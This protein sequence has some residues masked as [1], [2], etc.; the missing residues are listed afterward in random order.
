M[1]DVDDPDGEREML[2]RDAW[3]W[4]LCITSGEATKADLAALQRWCAQSP[5]HADAFAKA[6]EQWR[7]FGPAI[8]GITLEDAAVAR[9][10]R[11][12]IG[13]RAVLGGAL[14]ASAAGVAFAMIRPPLELWPSVTELAA[15]YRT[16]PGEQRQLSLADGISVELNT[17]T[18]LNIRPTDRDGDRIELI[19]GEAAVTTRSKAIEVLAGD[20]QAQSAAARFSVRCDGPIVRVTC[21][22]GL[23]DIAQQTRSA[24]IRG[25]QQISYSAEGLGPITAVDAAIVTGWREGELFFDDEPLSLVIDELNRY[26]SGKIVLMNEALGRRRFTARFKLDRL[27]T[28][29]A[30]LQTAFG[31]RVTSFPGGIVVIS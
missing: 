19:T 7:A 16:V 2:S 25:N 30:Q 20:G 31:A 22:D 26:R 11:P 5:R 28:A 9:R 13:R 8:D 18:S 27:D 21:L 12:L 29:V 6:S 23:V 17:R 15:D 1:T 4:V 10:G 24:S 3:N 14:A